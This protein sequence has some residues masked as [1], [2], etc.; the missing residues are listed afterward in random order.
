MDLLVVD[1]VGINNTELESGKKTTQIT[2]LYTHERKKQ[3]K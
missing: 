1:Q 2:H 3:I